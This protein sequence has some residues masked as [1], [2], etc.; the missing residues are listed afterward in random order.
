[1][2]RRLRTRAFL[3]RY[4]TVLVGFL[5]LVALV[6]AGVTV[7]AVSPGTHTEERTVDSWELDSEFSHAANVTEPNP[8]FETGTVLSNRSAY[9]FRASPTLDGTYSVKYDASD[10]GSID[11]RTTVVLVVRSVDDE[12]REYWHR[13]VPLQNESYTDVAPGES[14]P[15]SFSANLNATR[16]RAE[17]IEDRLDGSPGET[18]ARIVA[19]TTIEGTV[20]ERPVSEQRRDVLAVTFEQGVYRPTSENTTP[21]TY[22]RT[23]SVSVPDRPGSLRRVG[24]PAMLVAALGG[25]GA[26]GVARRRGIELTAAERAYLQ[27]ADDRA[28]FDE[29]ITTVRLPPSVIDAP[30]A[31]AASLAD[32]VDF[33]IDSNTGVV[34]DPDD[35]VYYVVTD[36][37][38]YTY[39]P[40]TRVGDI[41][42][43]DTESE[44]Q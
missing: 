26:V 39:E 12:G 6:G 13:T 42:S 40:P 4:A 3:S 5:L 34:A 24:G 22:E 15:V 18:E 44:S 41:A 9:F 17:L 19:T 8:A 32:L 7:T 1:M 11:V 29:W 16:N 14:V 2:S 38:L 21:Q 20:N 36:A 28:E 37:C 33:A 35:E 10:G 43:H 30:R 25:L 31:E 27:Y 23:E